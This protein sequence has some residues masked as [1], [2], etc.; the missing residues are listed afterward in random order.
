M[1]TERRSKTRYP[2]QLPVHYRTLSEQEPV[3]GEGRTLN[4][5][6]SGALIAG[7]HDLAEDCLVKVTIDWPTLL[8]GKTALQLVT[9]G[10]VVRGTRFTW[11]VAFESYQ[12]R[13]RR[14]RNAA[15]L[16]E[17]LHG[18]RVPSEPMIPSSLSHSTSLKPS[19]PAI[20]LRSAG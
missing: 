6:S 18:S 13:T 7:E 17:V 4:L 8:N 9:T 19:S 1:N 15:G 10:R 5:S 11:S 20:P 14:Q 3:C 12:F 2:L 16:A